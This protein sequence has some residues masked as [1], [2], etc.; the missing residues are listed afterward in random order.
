MAQ[1]RGRFGPQNGERAATRGAAKPRRGFG[2]AR[3]ATSSGHIFQDL[4]AYLL[5]A[6]GYRGVRIKPTQTPEMEVSD[7][8]GG[9]E[10]DGSISVILTRA[11]LRRLLVL[12]EE[13]GDVELATTLWALIGKS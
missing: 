3:Y 5:A 9:Q 1:L 8:V 7:F 12:C 4:L 11:Q 10:S 2:P 13:A 6:A